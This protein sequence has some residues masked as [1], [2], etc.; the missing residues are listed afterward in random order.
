MFRLASKCL[1]RTARG[2]A[3]V[4]AAFALPL[5][6]LLVMATFE[7]GMVVYSYARMTHAAAEGARVGALSSTMSVSE[8]STAVV[9]AAPFV[10]AANVQVQV[11]GSTTSFGSRK[12]GDRLTVTVSHAYRPVSRFIIGDTTFNMSVRSEVMC[13]GPR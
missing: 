1:A 13:E 10:V 3:M 2:Q 12:V 11:S 9:T 4:E 6:L 5:F 7:G 8:V